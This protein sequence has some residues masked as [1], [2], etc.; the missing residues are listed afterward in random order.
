MPLL[1]LIFVVGGVVW[2]MYYDRSQRA[3]REVHNQERKLTLQRSHD[4][5]VENMRKEDESHVNELFEQA[6]QGLNSD[7]LSARVKAL[8]ALERLLEK[9]FDK[10]YWQIIEVINTYLQEQLDGA[11]GLLFKEWPKDLSLALS[12]LLERQKSYQKLPG[13]VRES[14]VLKGVDL[15]GLSFHKANFRG[16][17]LIDV[18]LNNAQLK[19]SDFF[20]SHLEK[21][22]FSCANLAKINLTGSSLKDV[23]FEKSELSEA[24]FIS[25]ELVDIDFSKAKLK[26]SNFRGGRFELINMCSTELDVSGITKDHLNAL[27]I[28]EN[29]QLPKELRQYTNRLLEKK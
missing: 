26:G 18:R 24:I 28:D 27:I 20:A 5:T 2:W 8:Y 9:A 4:L 13:G 22:D 7:N 16:A 10:P 23:S 6:V 25:A 19:A 15:R 29:T 1:I 21:V 3:R 14:I 11:N 12:I 17:K